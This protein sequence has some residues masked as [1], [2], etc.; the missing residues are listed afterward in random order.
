[1]E[2]IVPGPAGPASVPGLLAFASASLGRAD[3]KCAQLGGLGGV[4]GGGEPGRELGGGERGS[5]FRTQRVKF[6]AKAL[7]LLPTVTKTR[8]IS[9]P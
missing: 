5:F 7:L 2:T 4:G 8:G 9:H 3:Q 6:E 1:M